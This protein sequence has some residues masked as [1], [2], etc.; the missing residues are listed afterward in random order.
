MN[1]YKR[2]I[3]FYDKRRHCTYELTVV[4]ATFIRPMKQ[5]PPWTREIGKEFHSLTRSYRLLFKH[6]PVE[7]YASKN[8]GIWGAKIGVDA[9]LF[10]CLL[11]GHKF[12]QGK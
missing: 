9:C 7:C 2:I 8:M 10:V 11:R 6:A 3:V 12:G 4:M 5:I 1:D